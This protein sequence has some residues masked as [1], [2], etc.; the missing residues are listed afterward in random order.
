MGIRS[1]NCKIYRGSKEERK[2]MR[3]EKEERQAFPPWDSRLQPAERVGGKP[4]AECSP[5]RQPAHEARTVPDGG[6]SRTGR[7]T[8]TGEGTRPLRDGHGGLKAWVTRML[9]HPLYKSPLALTH[10]LVVAPRYTTEKDWRMRTV[11]AHAPSCRHPKHLFGHGVPVADYRGVA[12]TRK[13]R[14]PAR[15]AAFV[16]DHARSWRFVA[17]TTV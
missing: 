13:K 15:F 10:F 16:S 4:K 1:E 6:R 2:S 17:P 7:G 8:P 3:I 9:P 11:D 12:R 14:I 5:A